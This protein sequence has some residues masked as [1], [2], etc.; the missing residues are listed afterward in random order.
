MWTTY[1]QKK[2]EKLAIEL[3]YKHWNSYIH[4]TLKNDVYILTK[5]N[6]D[7]RIGYALKGILYLKKD[8]V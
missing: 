2:A 4:I 8:Y 3:S 5:W 7:N 1:T 6:E